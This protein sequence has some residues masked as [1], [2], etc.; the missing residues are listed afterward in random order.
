MI[1]FKGYES[2]RRRGAMSSDEIENNWNK[3]FGR[4]LTW[5]ERKALVE[6]WHLKR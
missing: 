6:A 3:C 4:R 5:L 1:E 2:A